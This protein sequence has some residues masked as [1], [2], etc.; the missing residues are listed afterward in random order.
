MPPAV[1]DGLHSI[2]T[3]L[4]NADE[5]GLC[6]GRQSPRRLG[7]EQASGNT[8]CCKKGQL[9]RADHFQVLSVLGLGERMAVSIAEMSAFDPNGLGRYAAAPTC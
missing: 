4:I 9:L 2:D 7:Q 6:Y 5:I 1:S 3:T 8:R